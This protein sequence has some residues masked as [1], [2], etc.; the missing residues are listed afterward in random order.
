[1]TWR[2]GWSR[3]SLG[4]RTW[5]GCTPGPQ[6]RGA[7]QGLPR[8]PGGQASLPPASP[9]QGRSGP[10]RAG[11][12]QP[13][14]SPGPLLWQSLHPS[15]SPTSVAGRGGALPPTCLPPPPGPAVPASLAFQW[16]GRPSLGMRS[17]SWLS[18]VTVA[19]GQWGERQAPTALPTL[20]GSSGYRPAGWPAPASPAP[21]AQG[22][23]WRVV[24]AQGSY[25]HSSHRRPKVL[26][27]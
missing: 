12:L 11:P 7:H 5:I 18:N 2:W 1:M 8:R 24:W 21:A 19:G 4:F 25:L 20:R 15:I 16:V 6:A 23:G 26:G 13:G 17:G 27:I 3:S 14:S 9:G 22:L 10:P